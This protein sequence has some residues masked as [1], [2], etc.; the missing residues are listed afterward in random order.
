V[1]EKGPKTQLIGSEDVSRGREERKKGPKP[2][3]CIGKKGP[4]HIK[5]KKAILNP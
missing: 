4:K 3:I 1:N 5:L 2:Q